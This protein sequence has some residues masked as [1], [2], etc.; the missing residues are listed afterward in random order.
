MSWISGLLWGER[1]PTV[2]LTVVTALLLM[3]VSVLGESLSIDFRQAETDP[4]I[5]ISPSRVPTDRHKLTRDGMRVIQAKDPPGGP[6]QSPGTIGA[7][8]M[9]FASGDF[10]ATLDWKVNEINEPESGWGQGVLFAADLDDLEKTQLQ[11]SLLGRPGKGIVVRAARRGDQVM[12]PLQETF[13]VEFSEGQFR[14]S[15][16]NEIAIFSIVSEGN[17]KELTRFECPTADLRYV[18][19]W[20]TRQERGNTSGDYLFR[21]LSVTADNFFTYQDS[22]VS[23]WSWWQIIVVIQGV[24]FAIFLSIWYYQKQQTQ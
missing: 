4:L 16:R 1:R 24:L 9:V 12:E 15:R 11:M 7:K 3:Q 22:R 19:V 6:K 20:C 5:E 13:P 10:T 2:Y 14:I 8:T 18:A 23:R 17:E 21:N